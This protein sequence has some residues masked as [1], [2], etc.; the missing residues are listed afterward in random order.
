[1]LWTEDYRRVGMEEMLQHKQEKKKQ[2]KQQ[3]QQIRI[4]EEEEKHQA[5]KKKTNP[6]A[7]ERKTRRPATK[8]QRQLQEET[9]QMTQKGTDKVRRINREQEGGR[10]SNNAK[11]GPST[12][13]QGP[14]VV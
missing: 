14:C 1:M 8:R 11:D 6:P 4:K 12:N 9:E 3:E 7:V 5:K 10:K 2:D 13:N